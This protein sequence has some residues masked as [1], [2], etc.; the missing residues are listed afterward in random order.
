MKDYTEYHGLTGGFDCSAVDCD[1]EVGGMNIERRKYKLSF[2][3]TEFDLVIPTATCSEEC[4]EGY[5][6]TIKKGN[7]RCCFECIQCSDGEIS[8]ETD[9]TSCIKCPEDKWPNDKNQC[10]PKPVEYLS[11]KND[12][13]S[14]V[15][16]AISALFFIK[17]SIILG[18]FIIYRDTP[19]I[20]AN[21]Q[22]LSVLLLVSIMLSF[23]SILLFIGRP[24]RAS[25]MARHTAYGII[26]SVAVASILAKTIMVYMAFKANKPRHS[27]RKLAEIKVA[28]SVVLI[29]PFIQVLI[30][31]IW[32]CI[33]P[34]FPENNI[35]SYPGRIFIQCNEGSV[36]AFAI[37]L[38]YMGLLAAVTFI[39]AF[40]VRNLPDS[41]NEAKCI[42]FSMLVFCSVW[43]A[44][45]PV[46]MS[47]SGK[48]T[49][50]VEILAIIFSSVGVLG[51][52]F[53]PKCYII[54]IRPDLNVKKILLRH[55]HQH[56]KL[57]HSNF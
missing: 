35:H 57:S 27:W 47:V 23:L 53:L 12:P 56:S 34:P 39:A 26:F 10:F 41:F 48:N 33:S 51:C 21:N 29:C 55:A 18:M 25:C 24:M 6:R 5:R 50:L 17:T 15:V 43:I 28:N 16:S 31:L 38:G 11:Y 4:P 3:Q 8:N 9:K 13:I 22:N 46:Y 30:S 2:V 19:V 36:A 40:L 45:I 42:T 49:V 32:L 7:H 20:K 52:I 44:F 1:G 54:V 14:I 37:L